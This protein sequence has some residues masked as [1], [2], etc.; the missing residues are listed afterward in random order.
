M[1]TQSMAL[2]A[3]ARRVA[4]AGAVDANIL[5][6]VFVTL[7]AVLL[8]DI[9]RR[10]P[11]TSVDVLLVRHDF[12]VVWVDTHAVPAQVIGNQAQRDYAAS[13]GKRHAMRR[14]VFSV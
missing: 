4:L 7:R 8:T 5:A 2:L 12:D 9:H 10:A 3:Y 13:E 6:L 14:Y 1:T 11:F